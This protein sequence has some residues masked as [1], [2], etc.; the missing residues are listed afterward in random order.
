MVLIAIIMDKLIYVLMSLGSR[1]GLEVGVRLGSKSDLGV[2][3]VG[4]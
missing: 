4:K 1:S 2:K 3:V